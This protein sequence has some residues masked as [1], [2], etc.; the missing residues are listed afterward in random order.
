MEYDNG[1]DREA[2][3]IIRQNV[4]EIK[5]IVIDVRER[6]IRKCKIK[7]FNLEDLGSMVRRNRRSHSAW[8]VKGKAN[9]RNAK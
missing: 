4:K 6:N 2:A 1:F 7:E 5:E 3:K 9:I 8:T